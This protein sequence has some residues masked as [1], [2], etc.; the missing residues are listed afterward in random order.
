MDCCIITEREIWAPELDRSIFPVLS[1]R[2]GKIDVLFSF[3]PSPSF[4]IHVE[5]Y[6]LNILARKKHAIFALFCPR[7]DNTDI[8]HI[9]LFSSSFYQTKSYFT[10]QSLKF[11]YYI[12]HNLHTSDTKV[13]Y[14]EKS[15]IYN[16]LIYY[17]YFISN[18]I[19]SMNSWFKS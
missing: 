13:W 1:G 14:H 5:S 9:S 2:N 11:R 15:L 10:S 8:I 17:I 12:L 16:C 19:I 6:V 3:A 4:S 18:H 7:L